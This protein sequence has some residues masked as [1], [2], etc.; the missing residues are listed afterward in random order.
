LLDLSRIA[1]VS[2]RGGHRI[3]YFVRNHANQLL[4]GASLGLP[5][6]VGQLFDDHE[7]SPEPLSTNER[8]EP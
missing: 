4:V 3:V 1:I 2:A 7:T 6:F 5:Q 8:R